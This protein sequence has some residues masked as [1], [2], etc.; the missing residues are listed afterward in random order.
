MIHLNK[1]Q[2][3]MKANI[4]HSLCM[5]CYFSICTHFCWSPSVS[6]MF[7]SQLPVFLKPDS[8]NDHCLIFSAVMMSCSSHYKEYQEMVAPGE[9]RKRPC[10]SWAEPILVI[11]TQPCTWPQWHA[12]YTLFGTRA[13]THNHRHTLTCSTHTRRANT[14]NICMPHMQ[15]ND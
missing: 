3:I 2:R 5:I 6:H 7:L 15:S 10:L 8:A 11:T 9:T 4:E 14:H 13:H 12:K 1:N